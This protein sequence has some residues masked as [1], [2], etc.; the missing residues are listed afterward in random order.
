MSLVAGTGA[1]MMMNHDRFFAIFN[2]HSFLGDTI[3]RKVA[4]CFE[5]KNPMIYVLLTLVRATVAHLHRLQ[6]ADGI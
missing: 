3:A 5:P 1:G 4:Y 2:L 6:I